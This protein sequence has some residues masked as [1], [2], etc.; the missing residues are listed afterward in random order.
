MVRHA[1]PRHSRPSAWPW[2]KILL[3]ADSA[4]AREELLAW[5]EDNGVDY[6]IGL[7]KNSRLIEKIGWE[8]ADAQADAPRHG[9]PAR[10]RR[11]PL[12]HADELVAPAPGRRQGRAPARQG[13]P[14][15]RRH[16]AARRQ[17]LGPPRLRARLLPAGRHGEHHQGAAARPV[18]R[19]DLGLA[20]RRQPAPAPLLRL[21][22]GPLRCAQAHARGHPPGPRHRRN[23]PAQAPQD[24]RPRH[25]LGAQGQGR[26]GLRA[27]LGRRLRP[28][29]RPITKG[30]LPALPDFL[31]RRALGPLR[32][33]TATEPV[34]H[35]N[36]PPRA[37]H[38]T[39]EGLLFPSGAVRRHNHG[40][41]AALRSLRWHRVRNPG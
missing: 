40:L 26:H 3:R 19:P 21:R 36:P 1:R 14:P 6:V 32:P 10:R 18:L 27:S 28:P 2:L 15:L 25:R 11:V 8:L 23:A 38:C 29:P 41:D 35:L 20:L 9:R 37:F 30:N 39:S 22:L 33:R 4:Y 16:L 34:S 31:S 17:L 7:A 5:C 12:R 24:R 13:Q